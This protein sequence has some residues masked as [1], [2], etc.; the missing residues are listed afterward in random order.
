MGISGAFHQV[1][2]AQPTRQFGLV[3]LH[4]P[5]R[6][7]FA[8]QKSV[9]FFRRKFAVGNGV[10]HVGRIGGE[11]IARHKQP[12]QAGLV[13]GFAHLH[14]SRQ[15][16]QFPIL[17]DEEYQRVA[18]NLEFAFLHGNKCRLVS[19]DGFAQNGDCP[20]FRVN[21]NGTVPFLASVRF[22][23]ILPP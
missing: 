17:P 7:R 10:Y 14:P 4:E 2:I 16:V 8:H 6:R 13:V 20:D 9:D 23:E 22:V 11:K 18:G 19:V 1:V 5:R 3:H 12:F 21:E 15:H